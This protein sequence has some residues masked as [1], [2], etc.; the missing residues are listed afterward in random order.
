MLSL[1]EPH[2]D[3]I[4]AC[5]RMGDQSSQK[6]SVYFTDIFDHWFSVD[7]YDLAYG[8]DFTDIL[9]VKWDNLLM[10]GS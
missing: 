6:I 1:Q 9:H 5:R 10:I 2:S 7:P 3:A 4:V 8:D